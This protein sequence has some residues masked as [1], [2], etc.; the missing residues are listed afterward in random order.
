[1]MKLLI[2]GGAGYIGSHMV[3][4]AQEHGHEVVVLDDFSTGHQWAVRDC[5][6]LRVNLLDQ[7]KLSQML[8]GR[9]FDGVIHFAA[10]SLVGE[11]VKKPDLYY[12]NNVVGT[13]N[14]VNEMLNNDINNLV[15]SST[16]AIFGNPVTDKIAEDHP[17]N[18]INPYGQSK[19]MVENMLQD[20]CSANDFNATCLRY[21]NAAGADPSGEIGEAHDPET[22]LI[23]NILKSV[24]SGKGDL[25]V[26]GDDYSTPDGTCVRDYVHANDLAQAHLLGLEYMQNNK[27]F[28]AFNLGNGDGF[29]VLDVIKASE[30][31]VGESIKYKTSARRDGDPAVL[32]ADSSKAITNLGWLA[33][34]Q[35]PSYIIKSAW[36]WHKKFEDLKL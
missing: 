5:E 12:R 10:K 27:G 3:R 9:H 20:I 1:M 14:L 26:F 21:F 32:V 6:I 34:Y 19:L 8:K 15:F 2:P 35:D 11:S 7:D 29:S 16:A 17:K 30:E 23:P 24:L 13:L 25:K 4:Y 36:D 28:S 22:H 18:P 31:V 33:G